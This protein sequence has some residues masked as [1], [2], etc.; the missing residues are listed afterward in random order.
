MT[1]FGRL[2][3]MSGP[4]GVGKSTIRNELLQRSPVPLK[5][6]ISATTRQPRRGERNGVDYHFMTRDAFFKE[7]AANGFLEYAEVFG[8]GIYYGTLRREVMNDLSQGVWV[9]LEIDVDGA[10]QIMQHFPDVISIFILPE[11]LNI[12]QERLRG[13][14]TESEEVIQHRLQ[15]AEYEISQAK[16][17]QYK[18]VNITV[19]DAVAKFCEILQKENLKHEG[20]ND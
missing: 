16:L 2:I 12:L 17:Y 13:R 18:I 6:S 4:S 15:R 11:S 19:Q 9:L 3:I 1:H 10:K 7:I 8:K 5:R 20:K 14:A